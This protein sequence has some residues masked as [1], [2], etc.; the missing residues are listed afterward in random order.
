MS[1]QKKVENG[2]EVD[3]STPNCYTHKC[4]LCNK[5]LKERTTIGTIVTLIVLFTV[6]MGLVF[7][8]NFLLDLEIADIDQSF[9]EEPWCIKST[10]ISSEG[11][12]TITKRIEVLC[13]ALQVAETEEFPDMGFGDR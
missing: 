2:I 12:V 11:D 6:T 4:T 1:L 7:G 13:D 10:I 3:R 8:M 9:F 5:D